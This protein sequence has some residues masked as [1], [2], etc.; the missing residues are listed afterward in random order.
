M[1]YRATLSSQSEYV[2]PIFSFS[3]FLSDMCLPP[4][5]LMHIDL[6]K[7]S[8]FTNPN[9]EKEN[10]V[11]EI[12]EI[13]AC[14]GTINKYGHFGYRH[15]YTRLFFKFVAIVI[16]MK[17]L[18]LLSCQPRVTVTSCYQVCIVDKSLVY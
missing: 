17:F 2:M 1:P 15:G 8:R 10:N 4:Y 3:S 9:Y 18:A 13:F 5:L 7:I 11:I 6:L 14:F 16:D 12:E